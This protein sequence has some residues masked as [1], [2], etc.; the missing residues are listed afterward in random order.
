MWRTAV[1]SVL[2]IGLDGPFTDRQPE[3][4]RDTKTEQRELVTP[5]PLEFLSSKGVIPPE[6]P[7]DI[8][9]FADTGSGIPFCAGIGLFPEH[10]I[11][12]APFSLHVTGADKNTIH[13]GQKGV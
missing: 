9:G 13:G 8:Q 6:P 4:V 10:L 11:V 3:K 7:K 1:C 2:H 12:D 5:M